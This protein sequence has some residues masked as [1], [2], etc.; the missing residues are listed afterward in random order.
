MSQTN[1]TAI[2]ES[3]HSS[4][5]STLVANTSDHPYQLKFYPNFEQSDYSS[6]QVHNLPFRPRILRS[7][8]NYSVL[9]ASNGLDV[10]II[11]AVSLERN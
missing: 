7:F 9:L 10:S 2:L 1:G 5:S 11:S 6:V 4:D 3:I 8:E